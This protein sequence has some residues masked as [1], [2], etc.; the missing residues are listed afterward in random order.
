MKVDGVAI[1]TLFSQLFTLVLGIKFMFSSSGFKCKD[2]L[3]KNILDKNEI[4]NKIFA[5]SDF[6]IRTI[7]L[8]IVN[9]MF[10]ASSSSF[11]TEILAANTIILQLE[12]VI[13]YLFEGLANASS[14]F[15]GRAVGNKNSNLLNNTIKITFKWS[16]IFMVLLTILYIFFRERVIFL[17]TSIEEVVTNVKIYDF[18]III[19]PCI[20]CMSLTFYGV[21]TGAMETKAIRNST[22]LSMI[23]FIITLKITA[24]IFK[25]HG[26]WFA[27]LTYYFGRTIFLLIYLRKLNSNIKDKAA[28]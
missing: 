15:A 7:C 6:I 14:V 17:F 21:F 20:A 25:N 26:L 24:P 5:N 9:N 3:N 4:L 12:S 16:F 1:A 23:L 22:F 19:Y 8:L 2:V 27:F 13:S 10:M 28:I 11:G 18:W